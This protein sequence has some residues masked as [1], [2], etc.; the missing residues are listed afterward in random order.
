V[1]I[2]DNFFNDENIRK[3]LQER[4]IS[5][6]G[7]KTDY[8]NKEIGDRVFFPDDKKKNYFIV[9]EKR[10][11]KLLIVNPKTKKTIKID[12]FLVKVL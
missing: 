7:S 3:V 1:Y 4:N 2:D 10:C 12:F 5:I 11:N 9:I 6:P 8:C